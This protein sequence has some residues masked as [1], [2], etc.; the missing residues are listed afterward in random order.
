[1]G[2]STAGNADPR[3]KAA[4]EHLATLS[5]EQIVAL[6]EAAKASTPEEIAEQRAKLVAAL[7]GVNAAET[8]IGAAAIPTTDGDATTAGTDLPQSPPSPPALPS[9]PQ[10]LKQQQQQQRQQPGTVADAVVERARAGELHRA[11]DFAGA[12]AAFA[13]AAAALDGAG[14]PI[15]ARERAL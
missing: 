6:E 1:M 3:F 2:T 10:A 13:A 7:D 14:G 8:D 15:A 9:Q 4:M 5:P 11:G 12:A